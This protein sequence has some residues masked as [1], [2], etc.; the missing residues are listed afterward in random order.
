LW[1][2][3]SRAD[4]VALRRAIA[5]VAEL[6]MEGLPH[7]ALNWFDEKAAGLARLDAPSM[8]CGF[9]N[10]EIAVAPSGNLYPCERLIGE[11]RAENAMR[12]GGHVL[13][14]RDD[15]LPVASPAGKD[16]AACGTCSMNDLCNTSCRCSNFVRTG[17]V[18]TPDGLL[19][20]FNQACLEEVVARTAKND[21]LSLPV[22]AG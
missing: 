1:T 4:A 11:D 21:R 13:D 14:A 8:R 3:W 19:C 10:G 18:R 9:G 12:L 22:L 17:N 7:H 6:W 15:F 2:R 20:M 5:Q 16:A